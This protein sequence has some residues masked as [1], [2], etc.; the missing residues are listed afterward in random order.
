M[1]LDGHLNKYIRF[2]PTPKAKAKKI[3]H[4]GS[5]LDLEH[6]LMEIRA[7]Y[8]MTKHWNK[9]AQAERI[10]LELRWT[11]LMLRLLGIGNND[12]M[13]SIHYRLR[14]HTPEEDEEQDG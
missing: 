5:R 9:L 8:M 3:R 14:E 2:S 1:L 4:L 10:M 6:T 13:H 7:C 12:V 11:D